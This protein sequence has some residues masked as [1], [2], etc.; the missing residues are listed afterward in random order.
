MKYYITNAD[1]SLTPVESNGDLA[2]TE[3]V[4]ADKALVESDSGKVFI[5]DAIGEAITLPAVQDGLVFE[6]YCGVTTV[7]TNWTIVSATSVIYGSAQVAGAVV[8]ASAENTITLVIAKFL[9]GDRI[10][11]VSDGTNWY[12]SGDVVTSLGVTFTDV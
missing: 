11:L 6:F 2:Y 8:A 1:G 10:K 5:L 12:V 4:T 9:P 7:T 3:Q